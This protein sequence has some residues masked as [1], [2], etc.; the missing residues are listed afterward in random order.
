MFR[1]A[2][3]GRSETCTLPLD[4]P[5]P[6]SGAVQPTEYVLKRLTGS[7]VLECAASVR[8]EGKKF[9]ALYS[10]SFFL[11]ATMRVTTVPAAKRGSG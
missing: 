6:I 1:L 5:G 2:G 11:R 4:R 8:P 9:K 3:S 10:V 7:L